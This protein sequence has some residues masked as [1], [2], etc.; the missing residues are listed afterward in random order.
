MNDDG[1]IFGDSVSCQV[2]ESVAY[3]FWQRGR[4]GEVKAKLYGCRRFVDVLAAGPG[5][6]Y[7]LLA[8]G[9]FLDR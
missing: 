3:F 5:T 2:N 7:E 4:S 1:A 6:Q 8:D 9:I